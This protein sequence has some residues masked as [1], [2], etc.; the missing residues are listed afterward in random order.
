MP[1]PNLRALR[2]REVQLDTLR[3]NLATVGSMIE[4]YEKQLE[5]REPTSDQAR[6]L[7]ELRVRRQRIEASLSE[8]G[9]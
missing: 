2:R 5:G 3:K 1:L 9:A 8:A 6:E 7:D 4:Q